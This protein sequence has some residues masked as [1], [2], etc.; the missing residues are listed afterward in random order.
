MGG[1]R[2]GLLSPDGPGESI[3]DLLLSLHLKSNPG[4]SRENWRWLTSVL[5]FILVVGRR[6]VFMP[7]GVWSDVPR[8]FTIAAVHTLNPLI[9]SKDDCKMEIGSLVIEFEGFVILSE[10]QC[11]EGRS[12]PTLPAREVGFFRKGGDG[13]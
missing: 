2:L 5:A 1:G 10:E 4:S 9:L 6:F 7:H 3:T 11:V 13:S 8:G 12:R